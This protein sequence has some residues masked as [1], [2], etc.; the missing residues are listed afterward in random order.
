MRAGAS[1]YTRARTGADGQSFSNIAAPRP[2]ADMHRFGLAGAANHPTGR[3][4]SARDVL[5]ATRLCRE[6]LRHN[7]AEFRY[8]KAQGRIALEFSD[9]W[10]R[11]CHNGNLSA[12]GEQSVDAHPDKEYDKRSF[13]LRSV[14]SE[15]S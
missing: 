14:G 5:S 2:R 1:R 4:K 7:S 12:H 10:R 6:C 8:A 15:K 9:H 11:C 3:L 13:D